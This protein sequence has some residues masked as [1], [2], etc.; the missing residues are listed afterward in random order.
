MTGRNSSLPLSAAVLCFLVGGSSVACS[1]GTPD[2][3]AP[4]ES[5]WKSEI[6]VMMTRVSDFQAEIISD[7]VITDAEY[8]EAQ[9]RYRA[10]LNDGGLEVELQSDGSKVFEE[11]EDPINF[12]QIEERCDTEFL[13]AVEIFYHDMRRNP[14][15]GDNDQMLFEC[16][17][18]NK[19]E[20]IGGTVEEFLDVDTSNLTASTYL[21][22]V[23]DYHYVK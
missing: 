23:E 5:P 19:V 13:F 12:S 9:M 15:N 6:D 2:E 21:S 14:T 3:T 4:K 18:R 1:S 20:G 7:Y 16:L 10:C 8:D 17:K 11:P 22:C